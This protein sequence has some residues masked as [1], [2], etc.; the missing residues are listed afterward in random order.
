MSLT[1]LKILLDKTEPSNRL[2]VL[3]LDSEAHCYLNVKIS[4]AE[5]LV[6][7]NYKDILN[8]YMIFRIDFCDAFSEAKSNEKFR[9]NSGSFKD[10]SFLWKISPKEVTD[11]YEQ[12]F[13][14]FKKLKPKKLSF[15][16]CYPQKNKSESNNEPKFE[17]P[18]IT[19]NQVNLRN[20]KND[21]NF[22]PETKNPE[23]IICQDN[24]S[25][26]N[27]SIVIQYSTSDDDFTYNNNEP[28][29]FDSS[30]LISRPGTVQY[31]NSGVRGNL[32]DNISYLISQ[33]LSVNNSTEV[34]LSQANTC[35]NTKDLY[36]QLETNQFENSG[37]L[38]NNLYNLSDGTNYLSQYDALEFDSSE[39]IFDQVSLCNSTIENSEVMVDNINWF[40]FQSSDN[41]AAY[42]NIE[43]NGSCFNSI[44]NMMIPDPSHY[45]HNSEL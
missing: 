41:V 29:R 8:A 23:I 14:E 40:D 38:N 25:D 42:N 16:A 18:E 27:K 11:I 22:R 3:A 15:I 30:D 24:L 45:E 35:N 7:R 36:F 21:I 9:K 44:T 32:S 43:E 13:T 1:K 34:I 31:R 2:H 28:I 10:T 17:N 12:I 19:L 33:S 6:N 4:L 26:R 20:N 39:T 37:V 5:E